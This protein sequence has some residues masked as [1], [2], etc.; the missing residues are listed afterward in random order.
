MKLD[1]QFGSLRTFELHLGEGANWKKPGLALTSV[2]EELTE[3]H[4]V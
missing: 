2:K 3:E 1:E 4:R